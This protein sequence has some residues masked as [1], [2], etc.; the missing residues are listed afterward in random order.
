MRPCA[1]VGGR[2]SP[3]FPRERSSD[4]RLDRLRE[5]PAALPAGRRLTSVCAGVTGWWPSYD[6]DSTTMA[7]AASTR[8]FAGTLAANLYFAT[9]SPAYADK[10]NAVGDPR[11]TGVA[12]DALSPSICGSGRSG[13][14]QSS[15]RR[16]R[17]GIWRS[18]P[19]SGSAGPGPR[20]NDSA[21]TAPR[22]CCSVEGPAIA[23]SRDG[24]SLTAEFLDRWRSPTF[25]HRRTMGGALRCGALCGADPH[26]GQADTR[27]GRT[28]RGRPRRGRLPQQRDHQANRDPGQRRRSHPYVDRS[29]SPAQPTP[30]IALSSALDI[31]EPDETSWCCRPYDGCDALLLRTTAQLP[32]STGDPVSAQRAEG[33]AVP[34]LTYLSWHGLVE[35]EPPR[36]P[37]PDRPP[38]PP[39]R[40]PRAG[41]SACRD[42]VVGACGFVHLP[43][44]RVCRGCGATDE[45]EAAPVAACRAP[46]SPTPSTTSPIRR[47]RR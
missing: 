10:T 24:T 30:R 38:R 34:H 1:S 47:R 39:R 37:E 43:P 28:D 5:L 46:S 6:E 15:P 7:V 29:A 19:M 33:I 18:A 23:E 11:R 31:A 2:A 3:H 21:A 42:H 17:G 44:V 14:R 9:S 8:A 41:S 13:C 12:V 20:T 16:P 26:R 35:L 32:G 22:P 36:R 4:C 45:M 40:V 27:R 25:G